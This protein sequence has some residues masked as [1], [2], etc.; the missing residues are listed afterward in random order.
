MI[1]VYR[2]VVQGNVVIL[3]PDVTLPEHAVV[4]VHLVPREEPDIFAR[5]LEQRAAN[6]RYH[7]NIDEVIAEDRRER[8]EHSDTWTDPDPRNW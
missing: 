4:E 3:D 7:V 1:T 6:S 5:V 2:G 8:E